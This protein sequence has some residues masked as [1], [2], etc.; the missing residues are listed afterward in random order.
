MN[1]QQQLILTAGLVRGRHEMP[2]DGYLFDV[3]ENVLDFDQMREVLEQRLQ[4]VSELNLYVTGLTAATVEVMNYCVR[5]QV[6][7]TLYHF[8][9]ESGEYVAQATATHS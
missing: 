3:I 2:V 1:E 8:D 4:N 7:L 6:R 9:R 5:H